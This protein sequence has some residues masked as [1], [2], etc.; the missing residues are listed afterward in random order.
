ML[1][2]LHTPRFALAGTIGGAGVA[3]LVATS[4]QEGWI[5]DPQAAIALSAVLLVISGYLWLR[6][7][8]DWLLTKIVIESPLQRKFMGPLTLYFIGIG[9]LIGSASGFT[10]Q[11]APLRNSL[12]R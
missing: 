12:K 7:L 9:C 1:A 10:F 2:M 6:I 4:Q 3:I 11:L 5:W 8:Y